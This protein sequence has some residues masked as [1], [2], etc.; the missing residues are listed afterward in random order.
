MSTIGPF[1]AASVEAYASASGDSNPIHVAADAAAAAGLAAP[2]VQGM[3]VM[4]HMVRLAEAWQTDAEV[5]SAKILFAR[6]VSVGESLRVDGRVV[7]DGDATP[8][9][10]CTLRLVARNVG[11][12]VVALVD[13]VLADAAGQV[14]A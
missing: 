6:P 12:T 13:V 11:G 4:G 10:R 14:T 2:I 1:D 9:W 5:C 7:D 8:A 3:L